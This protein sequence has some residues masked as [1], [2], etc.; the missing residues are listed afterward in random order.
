MVTVK[1]EA[2]LFISAAHEAGTADV[3]ADV[4]DELT[5]HSPTLLNQT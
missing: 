3:D 5:E 2:S 1:P 4:D